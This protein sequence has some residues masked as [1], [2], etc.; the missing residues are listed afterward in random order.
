M[1]YNSRET[2]TLISPLKFGRSSGEYPG[3]YNVYT[4]NNAMHPVLAF[5]KLDKEI[6]LLK[7]TKN[8]ARCEKLCRETRN[9]LVIL[10]MLPI[11]YQLM[12]ASG[13]ARMTCGFISLFLDFKL[14]LLESRPNQDEYISEFVDE[15]FIILKDDYATVWSVIAISQAFSNLK[16]LR[17]LI[18][19]AFSVLKDKKYDYDQYIRMIFVLHTY[20]FRIKNSDSHGEKKEIIDEASRLSPPTGLS[21]YMCH[22]FAG[23]G[24]KGLSDKEVHEYLL[25]E[26]Q[27]KGLSG[28]IYAQISSVDTVHLESPI[29]NGPEKDGDSTSDDSQSVHSE[30]LEPVIQRSTLRVVRD[31]KAMRKSMDVLTTLDNTED[32]DDL[33][34]APSQVKSQRALSQKSDSESDEDVRVKRKKRVAHQPNFEVRHKAKVKYLLEKENRKTDQLKFRKDRNPKTYAADKVVEASLLEFERDAIKKEFVIKIQ[35]LSKNPQYKGLINEYK[36]RRR[37][38][39]KKALIYLK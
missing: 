32:D 16:V 31:K 11:E 33:S 29:E 26:K 24:W 23:F 19:K 7:E 17:V 1:L 34:S 36:T 35:D 6:Q 5:S 4:I 3:V 15:V 22:H 2:V 12:M 13:L 9:I 18:K 27:P 28:A 30:Q 21:N 10:K 20:C 14:I 37:L 38:A 39:R 25:T 8:F